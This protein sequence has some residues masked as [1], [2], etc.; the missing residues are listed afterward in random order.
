VG[1]N[2]FFVEKR[3]KINPIS[4]KIPIFLV[5]QVNREDDFPAVGTSRGQKFGLQKPR[6]AKPDTYRQLIPPPGIEIPFST[7]RIKGTL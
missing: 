2:S 6:I 5:Q 3:V 7:H 1:K 4:A